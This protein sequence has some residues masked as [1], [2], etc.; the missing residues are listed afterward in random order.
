MDRTTE[1][2][3]PWY[4]RF[5]IIHRGLHNVHD[6]VVEHSR[7][8]ILRA[9]AIGLP[10]EVDVENSFD[11]WNFV[12]HDKML[13]KLSNG[14][15][16]LRDYR[17][18]DIRRLSLKY[19]EGEPMM[20]LE[21]LLTLVAGK[22]PLVIEFKNRNPEMLPAVKE[23]A[24]MLEGY[25]GLFAVHSF[26]PFIVE[27]F[28]EHY[29]QWTR[30]FISHDTDSLEARDHYIVCMLRNAMQPHFISHQCHQLNCW[31]FQWA[32]EQRLP[33]LAYTVRDNDDWAIARQYADN[34]FF[35]FVEPDPDDW[36]VQS[37]TRWRARAGE[38]A[39]R[40]YC[41]NQ[42]AEIPTDY[43][44]GPLPWWARNRTWWPKASKPLIA[45]PTTDTT[46][47]APR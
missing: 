18:A 20:T 25:S 32:I 31:T 45:R 2:A 36:R 24:R 40:R 8:A 35:E 16:L 44:K 23:A 12:F 5:P 11:G 1:A 26:N 21:E 15:G 47:D 13:D 10:I 42:P 6:G 30:G 33:I 7:T 43:A 17:G 46:I 22:V 41:K 9:L 3:M 14:S 34:M 29:P 4:L 27:W 19:T 37:K 28:A 39:D 38:R